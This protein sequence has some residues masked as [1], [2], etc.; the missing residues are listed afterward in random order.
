MSKSSSNLT[1]LSEEDQWVF[2][3]LSIPFFQNYLSLWKE[4]ADFLCKLYFEIHM[5]NLEMV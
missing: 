4:H 2:F 1:R 3:E 5:V